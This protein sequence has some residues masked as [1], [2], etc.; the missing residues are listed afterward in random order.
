MQMAVESFRVQI[1]EDM[2][3]VRGAVPIPQGS[4]AAI[5]RG[6]FASGF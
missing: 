2:G 5:R 4:F 1:H 6:T 3:R